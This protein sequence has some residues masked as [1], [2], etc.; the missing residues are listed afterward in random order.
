MHLL[1]HYKISGRTIWG[2]NMRKKFYIPAALFLLISIIFLQ[3][4]V[5]GQTAPFLSIN[6]ITVKE[7]E[8]IQFVSDAKASAASFYYQQYGMDSGQTGF[9]STPA[10]GVTP[11]EYVLEQILPQ[12]TRAKVTQ[13][14]MEQYGIIESADYL[15]FLGTYQETMEIRKQEASSGKV[16]Y[17]PVEMPVKEFYSY[18]YG[19]RELELRDYYKSEVLQYSEEDLR[20]Y[21]EELKLTQLRPEIKAQAGFYENISDARK[22]Q[23]ADLTFMLDSSLAEKENE[24]QLSLLEWAQESEEGCITG[25]IQYNGRA[26]YLV[27]LCK[28]QMPFPDFE[29]IKDNLAWIYGN[30]AFASYLVQEC[31]QAEVILDRKEALRLIEDWCSAPAW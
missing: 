31:E 7:E 21:Y 4:S 22:G 6:D 12:I 2:I 16:I 5:A 20:T 11:A 14:K 1:Y 29:T 23:P 27:L 13:E 17:G 8:F 25:P 26:G 19:Q 18:Y 24:E 30:T 28:G 10:D 15:S 9:W 3:G